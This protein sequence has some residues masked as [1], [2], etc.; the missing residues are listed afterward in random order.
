MPNRDTLIGV[1]V[2]RVK[3]RALR[4]FGLDDIVKPQ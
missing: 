4:L 3:T 1:V 2:L